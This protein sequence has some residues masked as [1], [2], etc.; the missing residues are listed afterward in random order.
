MVAPSETM[1]G[2]T[3]QNPSRVRVWDPVV[4]LFH[5]T[6]VAG[7]ILN[8]AV[9]TDGKGAHRWIGYA[10][11]LALVI[12]VVWGFVGT[13]YARFSE[14]V[15]GPSALLSYLKAL[16]LGRAPR[17]LGHNPAGAVM[18]LA[19]MALLA[20]VSLT[21]WLLTLD[22]GFGNEALEEFHEALAYAILPLVALHVAAALFESWK[23]GENLVGSM[24]T[25]R[26]RP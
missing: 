8:L 20:A 1:E 13:R 15:P 5:W 25:G 6:V 10:V 22:A 14:F 2:E 16:A 23:H 18:M 12:R 7:C 21:G 24:I 17:F 9:F 4:R 26:K 19:L 3:L 11:A